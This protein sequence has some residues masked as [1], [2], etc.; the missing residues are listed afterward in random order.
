[1]PNVTGIIETAL[2]VADLAKSADFYRGLFGFNTLLE[3][4]RLIA[5]DVAGRDVLLLFLQGA[6]LEPAQLPGGVIPPHGATGRSHLAFSIAAEEVA[7]WRDRLAAANVEI[8]GEVTWPRGA[9]SLYFRDPDAHLVEL[10]TPGF[11]AI[12]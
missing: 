3:S 8:E 11:W 12:Y 7:P 6:T 4:D 10:L 9:Q 2:Y 5:L 1:M